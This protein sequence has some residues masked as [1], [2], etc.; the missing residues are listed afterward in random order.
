[1]SWNCSLNISLQSYAEP[2]IQYM[3]RCHQRIELIQMGYEITIKLQHCLF[4]I[5]KCLILCSGENIFETKILSAGCKCENII[6]EIHGYKIHEKPLVVAKA[7]LS[8][9][10]GLEWSVIYL[11]PGGYFLWAQST[12]VEIDVTHQ[13]SNIQNLLHQLKPNSKE[14]QKTK[15]IS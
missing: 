15:L 5:H 3:H 9:G 13:C 11:G 4:T 6:C 8:C 12:A 10:I 1:M 2:Y 14:L 7:Q